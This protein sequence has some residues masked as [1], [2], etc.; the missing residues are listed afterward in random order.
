MLDAEGYPNAF[1]DCGAYRL[2]L[3][4]ARLLDDRIEAHATFFMADKGS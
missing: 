2:E 4:D 1:L 3:R